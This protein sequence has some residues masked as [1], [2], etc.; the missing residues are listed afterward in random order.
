[1]RVAAK[2]KKNSDCSNNAYLTSHPFVQ[3]FAMPVFDLAERGMTKKFNVPPGILLRLV[4]RSA[5]VGEPLVLFLTSSLTHDKF[6]CDAP[7]IP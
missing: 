6:L 5:Y 1:M 7:S 2:K 4:V 3:V